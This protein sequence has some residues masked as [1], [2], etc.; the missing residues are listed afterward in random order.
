MKS[1]YR[2][3]VIGG[4]V[5]GAS[6]LYHLAKFGWTDVALIERSVLTAGSS[7]HAAGGI[8]ALNADPNIAALQAYTIDLLSEIEKE[9]GQNIGLHMT[10]GLT[11]AGTPDRWEWLQSAYRTFQS[12]GIE[13]CRLVTVEE[14]CAL[15]PIM[16]GEGLLG[17][18]WADREGYI[19]TTGTVHAYAG[20]A[21]KRGATVIEH[22][23]VLELHQTLEGWELITEKGTI[24]CE[25]VVNAAGL[26]AKQVGR[27]AGIELPVSPLNH[28]Y[29]VSDSIPKLEEIDFEV[30]MTVDLEGFTYLRQDQKGVLLGIYEVDHQH[31]MMDGAPWEYGFELQQEDPDRIEKELIMGFERYPVLQEVGVKTWVN[32]A[33]TFSPDGNPLVG[34]VPGKRNYWSACAV[35]AGF[36]QGGGVGKSL[37][38][39]MIHGE[40]EADVYGMDVARYGIWAENKQ[41]I[42]ETTGQFYSRRFVMTYP[43]E[44]LPAGRPLRMNGIYSDLDARGA[45]WGQSWD[46]EVPLYFA[47]PGFRETPSLKR[48]NAHDIVGAECRAVREGVGLLDITAFSRFEVT[49]ENAETWLDMLMA[50][51]LPAPGRVK[52]AP[53]LGEDGRM[54]GDLTIFNWGDGRWWITGSYYLRAWHMRWFND[55]MA[56]GVTVRDLGEEMAGMSLSGPKSREVLRAALT[57]GDADALKFMG[58]TQMDVGLVRC[59]VG[60]LSVAGELGFELHCRTG[61]LKALRDTLLKAGADHGMIEYGFNALLSLRLEKSFGIWSAEFTQGYTPGMTGMDRW[62]D[63]DKQFV[64]KVAAQKERDGNGPAKR[65]VT[66]EVDAADADASGFEPVW[67]GARKVGF[68]TSGG[69]GH[70]LGKSLAMALVDPDC[71]EEG[72]EL[73]VHVVG[74]ERAAKVIAPSPYDPEGK[75]MRG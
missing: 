52:L 39:W 35:M 12:I 60:R 70:T 75:A 57:D 54:K 28:H 45:V 65:L 6:V 42:K 50:S 27:M 17:G 38:E 44:Q 18:M 62:I 46:L 13:D 16:S 55:H 1:H 66:L 72:A 14:A 51:K 34:P 73:A 15:N 31:W 74:V 59:H 37:A 49:G 63:W 53:M 26:W 2:V 7:W 71:A 9:S 22:N 67:Q 58:C 20:A 41:Y 10:G 47:E 43:N 4:G 61:D 68:V 24:S 19:D 30:P 29:L 25:H 64:G 8:H 69:Y 23:R 36:L 33:F 32:G 5:V 56:D 48:S 21:K 11:M 3:V 40:P